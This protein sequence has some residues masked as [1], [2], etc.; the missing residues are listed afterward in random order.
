MGIYNGY[1][2]FN[3]YRMFYAVA[4]CLS[5]SKAAEVLCISQPAVSHAVK[6]LEEQLEVKLFV[7]KGKNI[8]LTEEGEKLMRYVQMA[9]NNIITGERLMKESSNDLTGKVRIGIYSHLSTVILPPIIKKFN[10]KYPNARF[11]IFSSTDNEIKEKL[12]NKELDLVILHY[13]IFIDEGTYTEEKIM[14]LESGFFGTKE[15]LDD[16]LS[17]K[18]SNHEYPLILPMKGFLDTNVLEKQLK[19]D[20]IFLRPTYRVYATEMKKKLAKE[21]LGICWISKICA[22]KELA[23]HELYE[24]PLNLEHPDM[25]VSIAYDEDWLNPTAKEFIKEIKEYYK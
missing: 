9:F 23:N 13:P 6:E 11:V 17:N 10:K 2:D 22:E 1:C 24:I 12:R 16:Y 25:T 20:N 21:G 5:F 3:K 18:D 4:E 14:T 7:R 19:K 15:Y 8:S